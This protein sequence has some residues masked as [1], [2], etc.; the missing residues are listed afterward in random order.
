MVVEAVGMCVKSQTFPH[1]NSLAI[2][3]KG[4][5]NRDV[6]RPNLRRPFYADQKIAQERL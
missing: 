6:K 4:L 3:K 2:I 1:I 5:E